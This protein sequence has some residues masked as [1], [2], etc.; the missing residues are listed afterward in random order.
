MFEH[1]DMAKHLIAARARGAERIK[2]PASLP[3]SAA[4]AYAVQDRVRAALG[5]AAAWKVGAPSPTAEPTCA[6]ILARGFDTRDAVTGVGKNPIG[7]ELEIAFRIG[8]DFAGGA[9]APSAE[10]VRGAIEGAYVAI[11]TCVPRLADGL[12]APPLAI[13]ADNGINHGLVLGQR[14]ENWQGINA[15]TLVSRV[16]INGKV[17]AETTGGHSHGDI[18]A[19]LV[20]QVGHCVIARGGLSAGTVI[21]TGS[22]MGLVWAETPARVVGTFPG[23]GAMTIELT[24]GQ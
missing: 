17:A 24:P 9:K 4:E 16:E 8:R 3:A 21:T 23:V 12:K 18:F 13:L 20:W 7:V 22:W 14:V 11:E 19:L 10:D 5:P 2:T 1:Q 15:K 6:P